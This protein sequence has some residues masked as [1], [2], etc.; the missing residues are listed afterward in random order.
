LA[1]SGS[2][3]KFVVRDGKKFSH[4]IDPKTGYPITHNLLSVSVIAKDCTS[5]DAYATAFLVVGM[6]KALEMA[7]RLGLEIYCIY[8][9]EKEALQSSSSSDSWQ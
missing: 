4:A 6:E 3:R 7:E 9:D 1:T 2:Y 5:A 8:A